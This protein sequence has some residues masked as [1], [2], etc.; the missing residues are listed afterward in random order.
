MARAVT[1]EQRCLDLA[2]DYAVVPARINVAVLQDERSGASALL[3]AEGLAGLTLAPSRLFARPLPPEILKSEGIRSNTHLL[4]VPAGSGHRYS[5]QLEEKGRERIREWVKAGGSYLGFCA[6]AT[7]AASAPGD[8]R[9][10]LA[11]FEV[12]DAEHWKR[13]LGTVRIA[14]EHQGHVW[15]KPMR[16]LNGPLFEIQNGAA[17]PF[18]TA[19]ILAKYLTDI[20]AH[21][22]M[23][24]TGAITVSRYG[25]GKVF[26]FS[27]HP[28]NDPEWQE[29]LALVVKYLSN[30]DFEDRHFLRR[31]SEALRQK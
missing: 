17:P 1:P 9:L 5:A 24:G 19:Q 8:H 31:W 7:L 21:G 2:H 10:G 26:L 16:Y 23:P 13:G 3:A 27:G 6:G 11:P 4:V 28:E 25:K 30:P 29:A 15:E 20:D 12:K 22:V 18:S 14:G